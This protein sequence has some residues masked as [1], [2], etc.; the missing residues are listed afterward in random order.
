[1]TEHEAGK[2]SCAATPNAIGDYAM[3]SSTDLG[4]KDGK[5]ELLLHLVVSTLLLGHHELA[6]LWQLQCSLA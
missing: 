6:K 5:F 4:L 1:M 3:V 2:H